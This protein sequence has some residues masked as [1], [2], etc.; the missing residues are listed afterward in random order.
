MSTHALTL[1]VGTY[2]EQIKFGTG[3][4]LDGKGRGIYRCTFDPDTGTIGYAGLTPD[5]V[6]PSYLALCPSGEYLYAVNELKEYVGAP[7]GTVSSFRRDPESGEL[8]FLNR[9]PTQGTDPCHIATDSTGRLVFAANFMSGSVIVYRTK[10]NGELLGQTDFVQHHGSSID[11]NRQNGPHAH[12]VVFDHLQNLLYV[13]DLGVDSIL[14][15][16]VDTARGRLRERSELALSLP[17]GAGPRHLEILQP[18]R[19]YAYLSNELNSTVSVLAVSPEGM[20]ILQTLPLLPE[21]FTGESTSADIHIAP[22]GEFLY[23]S[24]RGH[25]SITGFRIDRRS[26]RLTPLGHTPSSGKTPRNFAIDPSGN[27]LIAANQDSNNLVTFRINRKTGVL[28]QTGEPLEI[29]TPVCVKF[30]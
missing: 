6:N 18:D 12:S 11:P 1:Y 27:F 4:Y 23:C 20:K 30:L 26:G 19:K 21:D 5:V 10:E 9:L 22:S 13:P 29:P 25:D 28:S 16:E 2:T 3:K 8:K 17:P 14:V 7:T 24:N 15:Y